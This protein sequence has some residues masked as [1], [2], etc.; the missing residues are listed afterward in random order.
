MAFNCSVIPSETATDA[1]VAGTGVLLSFIIT[2]GISLIMSLTI[3]LHEF[4]RGS[5]LKVIRKLLLSLSDQQVLT[6]IGIQSVALAKMKTMVPYHFFI[7]WMLSLL[8]TATHVGTLLALVNDFKRDW[9]LRWLR[10]FFMF[11]NLVLS[12]VSGI[13]IL[14]SVMRDVKPT[15][16][17]ACV[18]EVESTGWPSNAGPSIAG[19]IGVMAGQVIFFVVGVWYLH[20]KNRTWLRA[21]QLVGLL[22]LGVIGI[23]AA[24]RVILLSQ[25]F[26][27]PSVPLSD[28]GEKDWSFGQL[29]P[30]LLL[31]LP[32]VS[33]V[34]IRRGEMKVPSPIVD[35][36][37]APLIGGEKLPGDRTSFQPNPFW[38][39][40]KSHFSKW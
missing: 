10:Q 28:S 33:A 34:E 6:G 36:H 18:W 35:D 19:T 4:R 24:I 21:V 37:L 40:Q 15:L 17:I 31:L 38:G 23:G 7:V 9:V 39:T 12:I 11:V 14:M 22:V 13:F 25:A 1:G 27:K 3:V 5:E 8:S 2:A 30:L 20:V 26:G 32:L 29:L 16:P